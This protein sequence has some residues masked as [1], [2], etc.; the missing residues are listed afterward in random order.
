MLG[1]ES[2]APAVLSTCSGP[3]PDQGGSCHALK[4]IAIHRM[5]APAE[6]GA[7]DAALAAAAAARQAA[8]AAE[9]IRWQTGVCG[10]TRTAISYMWHT[11]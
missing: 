2:A 4:R 3:S 1:A 9:S 7:P 10:I 6:H 8:I 5:D 11:V